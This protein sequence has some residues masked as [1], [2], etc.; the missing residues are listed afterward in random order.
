MTAGKLALAV[1]WGF[2]TAWVYPVSPA[3][4]FALAIAFAIVLTFGPVARR[5]TR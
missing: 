5:L 2:A 4:F 3:A 1:V